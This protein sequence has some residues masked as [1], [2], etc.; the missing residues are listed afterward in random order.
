VLSLERRDLV[1]RQAIELITEY[2]EG[3][4]SRRQRRRFEFHLDACPNCAAYIE[5]IR[6]TIRL[7]GSIGPDELPPDAVDEITELY[8]R[9]REQD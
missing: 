9:W 5:Q 2:L 8:R 1:C 4:L 6:V 3:T 7:S